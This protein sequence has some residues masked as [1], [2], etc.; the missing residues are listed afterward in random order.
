M[1]NKPFFLPLEHILVVFIGN[2]VLE[3]HLAGNAH[4]ALRAREVRWLLLGAGF[5]RLKHERKNSALA[6]KCEYCN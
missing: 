2:V 1:S 4:V 3:H 6:S 5:R